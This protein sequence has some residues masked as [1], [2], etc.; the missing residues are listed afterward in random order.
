MNEERCET[1]VI[2]LDPALIPR[3]VAII[4]DGNRRWAENHALKLLQGHSYG[5]DAVGIAIR[6]ALKLGVRVLTLYGFSTE[7]W[8]RTEI[9]VCFLID[10]IAKSI[11]ANMEALVA[12][13]VRVSAIGMWRELP[14]H[15][16]DTIEEIQA[17]TAEGKGL[18][19]VLAINYGG[20]ADIV[21]AARKL[22]SQAA[23][24]SLDP[25]SIDE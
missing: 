14:D 5:V 23:E 17:A 8:R 7:N 3:H 19:F 10:L 18:D 20:R 4:P 11:R 24:G 22:A 12:E 2:S 1:P 13:G 9:E 15:L 21:Q 6:T 16:V 25:N